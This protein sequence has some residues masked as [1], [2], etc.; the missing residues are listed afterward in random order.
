MKYE[1]ENNK[2]EQKTGINKTKI[3]FLVSIFFIKNKYGSEKNNNI[4]KPL[5]I[6]PVYFIKIKPKSKLDV[7][8]AND[9][10]GNP[11]KRLDIII[12]VKINTNGKNIKV[13]IKSF[14]IDLEI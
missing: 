6:V 11:E 14:S 7:I 1:Y 10:H 12:S 4:K 2:V 9:I 3:I 8:N 13:G 5:K